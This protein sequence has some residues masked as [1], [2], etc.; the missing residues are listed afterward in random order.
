MNARHRIPSRHQQHGAVA[1]LVGLSMVVLVGFAGLA[2]D[3][4]RL[5]VN[6]TE[7]QNAADACALAAS[8]ELTGAPNIPL[9]NFP[10]AENIGR[11][12]ATLNQVGFQNA[13]IAGADVTVQ[14][15]TSLASGGTWVNA[16]TAG[17]GSLYVRCTIQ[18]TGI[19]PWFMQVLGIGDQTVRALATATMAPTVA[20]CTAIPLGMCAPVSTPPYSLV[21]GQWYSGGFN[22]QDSLTGS[23]N[24][25]DFTPPQGGAQ[26]LSDALEGSGACTVPLGA[27]VGQ[28]GAIQSLRRAWNTRFGIYHP[29]Y[30]PNAANAPVPDRSGYSYRPLN[31]PSQANAVANFIGVRRPANAPYGTPGAQNG[32]AITGL[33][34]QNNN[35]VLQPQALAT[36]GADRRFVIA[37]L[38]NCAGWAGSQ[39]VPVLDWAC[40]FMLHPM[41]NDSSLMLYLEYVGLVSAPNSPCG[42]FGGIGNATSTGPLAPALVQ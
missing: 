4:G 35:T 22:N 32:N 12:V 27:Q 28:S 40:V 13:A 42:S 19:T 1:I 26:E 8:R 16:A 36:R 3:G 31:W 33:S 30:N 7:L 15:G 14:F 9:G 2:L 6:K 11:T 29:N 23:F 24:W 5:Y 20:P 38:V 25:I 17:A 41:D 39:T 18:E 34:V 10:I 37:P 21:P